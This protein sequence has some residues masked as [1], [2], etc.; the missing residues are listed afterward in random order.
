[1]IKLPLIALAL[2]LLM[3]VSYL[4]KESKA[5]YE[6]QKDIIESKA[7]QDVKDASK[8]FFKNKEQEWTSLAA[9]SS[10]KSATKK[11]PATTKK[12]KKTKAHQT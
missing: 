12:D 4:A 6:K 1:M 7:T 8:G 2:V 10:K 5:P 3:E 11:T 9:S